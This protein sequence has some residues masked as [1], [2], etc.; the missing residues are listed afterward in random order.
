M[1]EKNYKKYLYYFSRYLYHKFIVSKYLEF[2]YYYN[3]GKYELDKMK[4]NYEFFILNYNLSENYK[5]SSDIAEYD[6]QNLKNKIIK[7]EDNLV[8][9]SENYNK[10]KLMYKNI[11]LKE[12]QEILSKI[13]LEDKNI[14]SKFLDILKNLDMEKFNNFYNEVKLLD[15]NCNYEKKYL[16]KSEI[17]KNKLNKLQSKFPYTIKDIILS[18]DKSKK[19]KNYILDNITETEIIIS[20][21]KKYYLYSFDNHKFIN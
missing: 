3:F 15:L 8:N 5:Y 6:Y 21:L 4:N 11:R 19:Y 17:Y 9:I 16:K 2:S 13:N 14:I 12:I 7:M 18:K 20:K 1:I 10:S